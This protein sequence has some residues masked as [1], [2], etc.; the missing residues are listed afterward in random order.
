VSKAGLAVAIAVRLTFDFYEFGWLGA[1]K[2]SQ[3]MQKSSEATIHI[4]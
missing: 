4:T 1:S 2:R 3:K